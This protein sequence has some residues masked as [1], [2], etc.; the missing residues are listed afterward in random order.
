[1][2]AYLP[3]KMKVRDGLTLFF[4]NGFFILIAIIGFW[5]IYQVKCPGSGWIA[6]IWFVWILANY[7]LLIRYK[8]CRHCLYYGRKCPLG[9]GML[10]PLLFPKGEVR[11]FSKQKW[12]ILYFV[13]Y[14]MIPPLWMIS[15][16][17]FHW[18]GYVFVFLILYMILGSL[19]FIL[20]RIRCC[21]QCK[22]ISHCLLS[23][24]A[25]WCKKVI[26]FPCGG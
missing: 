24:I 21:S 16:L 22:M 20:A 2:L 23:R 6:L 18:N 7:L 9:W 26:P 14:A 17:V 19:L 12:P 4:F 10:L 15:A 1:M 25:S 5:G 11:R 13:S 3:E 8:L